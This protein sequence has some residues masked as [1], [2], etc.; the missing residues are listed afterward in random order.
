MKCYVKL[1]CIWTNDRITL[2]GDT[3]RENVAF[4]RAKGHGEEATHFK[5]SV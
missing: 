2:G 3:L 5:D 1:K 4:S